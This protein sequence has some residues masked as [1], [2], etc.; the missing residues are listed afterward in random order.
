MGLDQVRHEMILERLSSDRKIGVAAMANH[1]DV[2]METIRRDLKLLEDRGLLRRVH[3]GAIPVV[4]HSD[5]P[6][7]KRSRIAFQEKAAIAAQ[8]PPMLK[9]DMSIFL[10]TG[11]T[12][13]AVARELTTAPPLTVFTNSIDIALV[14]SRQKRHEVRLTGGRVRPDDN[15][16]VGYD[17]I[18]SVHKYHFDLALMGIVGVH[19]DRGF[20]DFG[21]DEAELRRV[22][23][24]QASRSV[25]LADHNKF[26][27]LGRVRTFAF[28]VV[29][30]LITD[31]APPP[32]YQ[33][34]LAR[35]SVSVLHA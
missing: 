17:A 21:D 18:E 16:L 6:F 33:E 19:L 12:T 15:A 35:A 1:L 31:K 10:D 13:L 3:G 7:Q 29:D 32:A 20:M 24:A 34:I 30:I 8:I 22:A 2:S 23:A 4:P 26:G 9:R 11:T 14:V 25:I 27:R 5:R 28:G